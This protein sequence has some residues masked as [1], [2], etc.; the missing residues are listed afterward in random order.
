[1][2]KS[3]LLFWFGD[4]LDK[5][6]TASVLLHASDIRLFFLFL[7]IEDMGCFNEIIE[8]GLTFV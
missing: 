6:V 1:M 3:S 8:V 5:L 2:R 4:A 7:V